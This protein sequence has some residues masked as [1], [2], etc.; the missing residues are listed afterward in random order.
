MT[1]KICTFTLFAH[2]RA[3]PPATSATYRSGDI[4]GMAR[5]RGSAD[6]A[7]PYRKHLTRPALQA[8]I[9]DRHRA[10]YPEAIV[11]MHRLRPTISRSSW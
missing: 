2:N 3:G 9:S 11:A 4:A 7:H 10:P 1:R 5:K 8:E 6:K